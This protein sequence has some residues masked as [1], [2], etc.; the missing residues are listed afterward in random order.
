M[1]ASALVLAAEAMA[2]S[3]G[4]DEKSLAKKDVL[5]EVMQRLFRLLL[6]DLF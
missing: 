6:M 2:G 1:M 4:L 3:S 5:G